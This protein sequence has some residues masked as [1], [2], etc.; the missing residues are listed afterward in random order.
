MLFL[1]LEFELPVM[2]AATQ[3]ADVHPAGSAELALLWAC[4]ATCAARALV[5]ACSGQGFC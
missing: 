4:P 1:S 3:A 2:T 5:G